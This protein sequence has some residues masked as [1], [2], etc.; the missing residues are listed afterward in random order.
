[1]HP[2]DHSALKNMLNTIFPRW[3]GIH[4]LL[5]GIRAINTNQSINP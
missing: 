5:E 2:N 4:I 3:T 1:M